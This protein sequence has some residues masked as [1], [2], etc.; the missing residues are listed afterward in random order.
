VSNFKLS[1]GDTV[2]CRLPEHSSNHSSGRSCVITEIHSDGRIYI[3]PFTTTLFDRYREY[4]GVFPSGI[5]GR[6]EDGYITPN[7]QGWCHPSRV[8]RKIGTLPESWIRY[9]HEDLS[10][11]PWKIL[12]WNYR[13]I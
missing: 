11:I 12:P 2:M 13:K 10:S 6:N 7:L 8:Y 9:V 1:I 4:C 5:G 3:V